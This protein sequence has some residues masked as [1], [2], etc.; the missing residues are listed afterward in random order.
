[1]HVV[2][3]TFRIEA[4]LPVDVQ[5]VGLTVVFERD[6]RQRHDAVFLFVYIQKLQLHLL[7][8]DAHPRLVRAQQD[9]AVGQ[10]KVLLVVQAIRHACDHAEAQGWY[11]QAQYD[12]PGP[13]HRDDVKEGMADTEVAVERN[14]GHDEGGVRDGGGVKKHV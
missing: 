5:F 13:L 8:W 4:K 11:C 9:G 1:M 3:E 10:Q 14:G 6:L 2:Q 7:V 12:D